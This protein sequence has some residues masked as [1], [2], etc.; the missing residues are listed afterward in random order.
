[1]DAILERSHALKQTIVDFVLEAEGDLAQALESYAAGNLRS[2]NGN[3][4]QQDLVI[5]SFITEGKV[6]D[7]SPLEL[8]IDSYPDLQESDRNLIS[9]WHGS[10]MGL[11]AITEILPDGFEVTNWLTDKHYI[12]KPNNPK[13]L[14]EISRLKE[15]E[16]LLTRISPVTDSYWTFFGNYTIMGKLGKPKL[17]VAIG[18]FKE[19]YKNHLYSDAPDLLAE[20]WNSVVQ[21]HEQFVEFFGQDEITLPGYQ[22]NKKIAEFQE[23]ITEKL[24]ANTGIDTSKPLAEMAQE[25][26]IDQE[27]IKAAVKEMGAD[28]NV[29]SQIFNNNG[30]SKMVMPKVDL[31]AELKK[32]EQV[33]A[34]SHPRW[35]QIFLPTYSKFKTILSAENWQSIEGAEK[36]IRFYLEDKSINA[37]IWH[38]LAQEYPTSLENL[39]QTFLQRPDF[40]LAN[41]LDSLLQEFGKPLEPDLPE[42]ASVPVHLHNLF[43]AAIA[44]VQKSKPQ[45]KGQ[46]K[47]AKGFK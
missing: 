22:L 20:A 5:D 15:G 19:N 14:Q 12:V 33:T 11:F 6:G 26:G 10:F 17:A 37:F 34:I 13:T 45:S 27:E 9:S 35:G 28:S 1:M 46:K 41:D 18:N 25:A 31:P 39:L 40:S 36:L 4:T 29:A 16:I 21:Y 47:A 23:V 38:R 44:E 2:G 30:S 42:I 7:H 8:F 32:A 24:L 3:I 43:Q